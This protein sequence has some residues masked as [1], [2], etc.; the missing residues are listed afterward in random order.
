MQVHEAC[1]CVVLSCFS[2]RAPPGVW[3][4]RGVG[5]GN[6]S[7][8]DGDAGGGGVDGGAPSPARSGGEVRLAI[9]KSG[10]TGSIPGST[11]RIRTPQCARSFMAG[12][13][14]CLGSLR[15]HVMRFGNGLEGPIDPTPFNFERVMSAL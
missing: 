13:L 5:R 10:P 7:E 2:L 4:A 11:C 14:S 12:G 1:S 15:G 9:S 8:A 3:C 6:L